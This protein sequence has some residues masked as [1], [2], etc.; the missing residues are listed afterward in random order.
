MKPQKTHSWKKWAIVGALVLVAFGLVY[1]GVSNKKAVQYETVLAQ[2]ANLTQEVSVTGNVKAA[3]NVDLGFEVSGKVEK[4][5]V[6]VGDTVKTGDVLIVLN[7]D[8]LKAQMLQAQAGVQ[9]AQ[10]Q[11]LQFQ[12]ALDTQQSKLDELRSGTRPEEIQLAQTAVYNAQKSWD[13]AKSNLDAVKSKADAD[14]TESLNSAVTELTKA[15]NV[16]KSALLAL[17]DVQF[18]HFN[19]SDQDSIRLG[20]AKG[21]AVAAL[22]GTSGAGQ[23]VTNSLAGL[24]GG[25]TTMRLRPS[26]ILPQK[27]SI[28]LSFPFWMD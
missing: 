28:R 16:G 26:W 9:S 4:I 24:T 23:W 8:D 1:S 11:L 10:A 21:D 6:E 25:H 13:D 12:A 3:E 27:K 20:N 17:T 22:L 15:A 5:N 7:S 2:R 19:N 18:S 14:M